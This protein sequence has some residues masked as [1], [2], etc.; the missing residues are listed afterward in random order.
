MRLI[1]LTG[2]IAC[3]KS[4]VS[5]EL[6]RRGFSVID[7]DLLARE[8]TV[9]GG[10]AISS[11]RNVFGPRYITPEGA[12]NRREMSRLVFSVHETP[13]WTYYTACRLPSVSVCGM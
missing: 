6:I 1:G 8:L 4:T 2:S 7:G 12:M 9:P 3:G 10:A 13:P 5:H 11:I